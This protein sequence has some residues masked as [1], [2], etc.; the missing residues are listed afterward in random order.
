[1]DIGKQQLHTPGSMNN[2]DN[3]HFTQPDPEE[4]LE[5]EKSL[6]KWC[7]DTLEGLAPD[8]PLEELIPLIQSLHVHVHSK[9]VYPTLTKEIK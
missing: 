1:M 5:R 3:V 7:I 8:V 4:A 6:M 2:V 9:G